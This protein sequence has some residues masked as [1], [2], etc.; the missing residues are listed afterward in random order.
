MRKLAPF[1]TLRWWILHTAGIAA[2]Y[3]AGHLLFGG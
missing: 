2:V 1:L 3:A